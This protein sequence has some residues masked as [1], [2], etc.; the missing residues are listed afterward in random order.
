MIFKRQDAE[1][2]LPD[3][4]AALR[5]D[6]QVAHGYRELISSLSLRREDGLPRTVLVCSTQP[7]EGKTTVAVTL[8]AAVAQTGRKTLI[9]D[10][11][12]NRPRLHRIFETDNDKGFAEILRGD[13]SVEPVSRPVDVG[14][15]SPG[16]DPPTLDFIASGNSAGM[17]FNQV[18][19]ARLKA[20]VDSLCDPYEFVVID[21]AP[22]LATSD[23]LYLAPLA[24]GVVF[25]IDAGSVFEHRA[26]L[27]KQRLEG[28]GG[29]LLG[30]VLNRSDEG[31][32]GSG[33]YQYRILANR[34]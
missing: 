13:S 28:V 16:E 3:Y 9:L 21:T 7:D 10:A 11:D 6:P 22:V 2:R 4:L 20:I 15:A 1:S 32:G 24:E 17:D 25:V 30:F 18:G 33:Y 29:N 5:C 27:A 14:P 12:L 26:R 8:A 31:Q 34:A 19:R 23:A